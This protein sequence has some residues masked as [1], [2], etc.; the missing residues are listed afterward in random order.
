MEM[1]FQ[2]SWKKTVK[3]SSQ[4]FG[5]IQQVHGPEAKEH[6]NMERTMGS[7]SKEKKENSASTIQLRD[8]SQEGALFWTL[9]FSLPPGR[10]F[11]R[12]K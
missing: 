1:R 2:L 4:G 7:E 6:V 9:I 5:F 11:V 8:L 12:R 10:A 3:S